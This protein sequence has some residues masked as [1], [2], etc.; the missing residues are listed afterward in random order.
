MGVA[1]KMWGLAILA[2]SITGEVSGDG[3][4]PAL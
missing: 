3:E 4:N 2:A 1:M